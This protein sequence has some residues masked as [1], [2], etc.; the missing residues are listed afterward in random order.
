[1]SLAPAGRFSVAVA[2]IFS[3]TENHAESKIL[4]RIAC[5]AELCK[6]VSCCYRCSMV[7]VSVGYDSE[8]IEMPFGL[9][10][11]G[12]LRNHVLDG[13][14]HRL[15]GRSSFFGRGDTWTYRACQFQVV[16]ILRMVLQVATHDDATSCKYYCIQLMH[17]E[18]Q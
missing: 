16:D 12:G 15:T 2:M 3:L 13:D 8:S 11:S 1:M 10:T 17:V 7:C 9:W 14:L 18:V 6:D 5:I 4:D